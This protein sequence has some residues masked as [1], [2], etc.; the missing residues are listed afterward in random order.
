MAKKQFLYAEAERLYISEQMTLLEIASRL[1]VAERTLRNWKSEGGWDDKRARFLTDRQ[2]LHEELYE[3]T[4]S[5]MRNIKED[6]EENKQVDAGRLYTLTRLLAHIQKVKNYEDEVQTTGT[7]Q[8][9]G[10][11]S[12]SEETLRKIEELMGLR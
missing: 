5:L 7:E 2:S 4:R 10:Q 11:E 8:K 3:F 6:F 12:L 1:D 9:P